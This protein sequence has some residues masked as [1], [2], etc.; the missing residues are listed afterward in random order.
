MPHDFPEPEAPAQAERFSQTRSAQAMALVEDYAEMIDDLLQELG[1]ARITDIA[2]R[3]GVTHPTAA[4]AVAR[5]K[6]EGLANSRPYRGVFLTDAGVAMAA[7]VRARHRIVVDL[8]I[9]VGTPP[10]AAE[11]DAEGIEHFVSEATL[12][13]FTTFLAARA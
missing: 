4:K 5:L 10:E 8:L 11:T 6:R 13:A 3:L 7:R 9:A 1:E 12:A 2:R